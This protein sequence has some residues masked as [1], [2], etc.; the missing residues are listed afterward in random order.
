MLLLC[1]SE[2]TPHARNVV[3]S[4]EVSGDITWL[5]IQ[6][7]LSETELSLWSEHGVPI[8]KLQNRIGDTMLRLQV[9]E[10]EN[11]QLRPSAYFSKANKSSSAVEGELYA[12]GSALALGYTRERSPT[13]DG[14]SDD[15]AMKRWVTV[16]IGQE[17][18]WF[19]TG[20]IIRVVGDCLFFCGRRD[21]LVKIRGQRIQLEAVERIILEAAL[22][23]DLT[24]TASTDRVLK[25]VVLAMKDPNSYCLTSQSLVA[26]LLI[27]G[28]SQSDSSPASSIKL[29]EYPKKA[30]LFTWV[31]EKHGDAYVPRDAVVVP[32]TYVKRLA[33]GKVDRPALRTLYETELI[34]ATPM[35]NKQQQALDAPQDGQ[36][37]SHVK[38]FVIAQMSKAL[39]IRSTG[40]DNGLCDL[41]SRT[42][43][44]LG[45]NSLHATLLSWKLQQELG[46]TLPTHE[47]VSLWLRFALTSLLLCAFYSV[48]LF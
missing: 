36:K 19:R 42:F 44:E 40:D 30:R 43:Q 46:C 22:T 4:T 23:T 48:T 33:S 17:V 3:G 1:L 9:N 29:R 16:E 35:V 6:A 39:G 24:V 26:F 21:S 13:L 34:I 12:A 47:L 15:D 28:D 8:G 38:Q 2:L 10:S 7:P 20:D 31:R 11:V 41:R 14:G 27:Q 18:V 5:E 37:H 25:V 32:F 45:G